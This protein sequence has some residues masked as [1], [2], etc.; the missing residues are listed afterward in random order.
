MFASLARCCDRGMQ[1]ER[2]S[3][4]APGWTADTIARTGEQAFDRSLVPQCTCHHDHGNAWG[5]V[6]DHLKGAMPIEFRKLGIG[7]NQV[8]LKLVERLFE[9]CLRLHALRDEREPRSAQLALQ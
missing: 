7:Q 6:T 9:I 4:A 8:R 5:S 2:E 1:V 3:D